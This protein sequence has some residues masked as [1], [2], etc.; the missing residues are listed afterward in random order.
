MELSRI[1]RLMHNYVMKQNAKRG[2]QVGTKV[3][4]DFEPF[5]T[6]DSLAASIPQP[7]GEHGQHLKQV[8]DDAI[9]GYLEDGRIGVFIDGYYNI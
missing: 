5:I 3:M 4:V 2:L 9:G 7:G 8:A 1:A 6:R